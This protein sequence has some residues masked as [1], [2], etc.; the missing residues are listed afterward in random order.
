MND[1]VALKINADRYI[2][3]ALEEDITSGDISTSC[4]MPVYQKGQ[5]ELI[6]KQ[7]GIIA[8]LGVFKG[9]LKCLTALWILICVPMKAAKLRM[10]NLWL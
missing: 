7:D 5:A 1:P 3:M 4:V 2:R 8:G 10:G 9:Y 6:C